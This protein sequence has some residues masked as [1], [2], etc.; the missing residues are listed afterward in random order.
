MTPTKDDP[1][2]IDPGYPL[3]DWVQE[4]TNDDTRLGYLEWVAHQNSRTPF[5]LSV[6]NLGV[7]HY[8][9]LAVAKREFKRYKSLSIAGFGRVAGE[10]ILLMKYEDVIDEYTP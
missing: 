1:W 9:T 7:F 6:G 8:A 2:R 5:A 4:V 3:E 10:P